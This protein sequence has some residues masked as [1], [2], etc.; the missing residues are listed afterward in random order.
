MTDE[1]EEIVK[2]ERIFFFLIFLL[3]V[4]RLDFIASQTKHGSY[5]N[6]AFKKYV[7]NYRPK[8]SNPLWSNQIICRDKQ[9]IIYAGNLNYITK[10][11]FPIR[12][13]VRSPSRRLYDHQQFPAFSVDIK[14][15]RHDYV[16]D[17]D[18]AMKQDLKKIRNKIQN[19]SPKTNIDG[20]ITNISVASEFTTHQ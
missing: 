3:L 1:D 6:T 16:Y 12:L 15:G 8:E 17:E 9:G 19:D 4:F 2:G 7:T 14:L 18:I 20:P 13:D 10:D 11:P 5:Q